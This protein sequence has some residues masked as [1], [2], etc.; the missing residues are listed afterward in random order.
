[1]I[2]KVFALRYGIAAL[3]HGRRNRETSH[4]KCR[5]NGKTIN[6]RKQPA[7]KERRNNMPF[8]H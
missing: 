5:L 7:T 2:G 1:M 8:N 6:G 4:I 3:K